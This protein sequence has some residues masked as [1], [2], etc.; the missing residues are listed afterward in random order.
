MSSRKN[1]VSS[2]VRSGRFDSTKFSGIEHG[3]LTGLRSL[4]GRTLGH[5]LRPITH[6][7]VF[8]EDQPA[9]TGFVVLS[10]ALAHVVHAAVLLVTEE[11]DVGVTVLTDDLVRVDEVLGGSPARRLEGTFVD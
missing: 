4:C 6:V 3:T 7:V 2:C 1:L 8:V 11:R 9:G 10:G 5:I